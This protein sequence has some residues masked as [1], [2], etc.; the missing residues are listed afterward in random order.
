M[1]L[2]TTAAEVEMMVA[3]WRD[4]QTTFLEALRQMMPMSQFLFCPPLLRRPHTGDMMQMLDDLG[5]E[6]PDRQPPRFDNLTFR[7]SPP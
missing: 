3:S 5:L 1:P 6:P 2:P 4:H 7:W